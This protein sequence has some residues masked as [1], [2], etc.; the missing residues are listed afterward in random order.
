MFG[1]IRRRILALWRTYRSSGLSGLAAAVW[2]ERRPVYA[3]LAPFFAPLLGRLLLRVLRHSPRPD[4]LFP[5]FRRNGYYLLKD[6]YYRP[7]TD[8]GAL[9]A[10]Y[11]SRQS[12]LVGIDI[13]T[14]RCFALVEKELPPY[15]DEFRATFPVEK[16]EREETGFWL[17]NGSYMAVDAHLYYGF[18]RH[19][20]PRRI[21]EVGAGRSTLI[22]GEAC[23]RN[24]LSHADASRICCIE[25]YPTTI[26]SRGLEDVATLMVTRVEFVELA[27]FESLGADDMLFIDS[28]H[29]LREGGDVQF[30]YC[31]VLPR[32][33]S[34]VLVHIHDVSLPKPYPSVYLDHGYFWNEQYLLQGFL[35]NNRHAQVLWPGNYLMCKAPE[36][37]HADFPEIALMR[38]HFPASEPSAFWFRI[39]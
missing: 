4:V 2:D 12:A 39:I 38:R 26:V 9:P 25:P 23:R 7:F 24:N 31:E 32:L 18:V 3:R 15:L 27:F 6:H 17:I 30:L 33:C 34:G 1:R 19:F 16:P 21:V 29:A 5:L 36:R 10:D 14:E 8:P 22:A 37:M 11:W 13:D 35:T 20:R 28:S